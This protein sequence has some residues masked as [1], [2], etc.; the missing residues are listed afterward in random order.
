MKVPT[1]ILLAG[2]V[3]AAVAVGFGCGDCGAAP[4]S[5]GE[6]ERADVPE[7]TPDPIGDERWEEQTAS[8]RGFGFELLRRARQNRDDQIVM[9][10]PH[11]A[12][13]MAAR[14]T[15]GVDGD[16]KEDVAGQ[17]GWPGDGERVHGLLHELNDEFARQGGGDTSYEHLNVLW[18]DDTADV[19]ADVLEGLAAYYDDGIHRIGFAEDVEETTRRIDAWLAALSN[20][21]FDR[22]LAGQTLPERPGLVATGIAQFDG[23]WQYGF[24][25]KEQPVDF[26]NADGSVDQVE[27]MRGD[28]M[29]RFARHR[30]T[31][32]AAVA[33]QGANAA[34][35]AMMPTDED[36]DFSD[37]I[38]DFDARDFDRVVDALGGVGGGEVVLPRFEAASTIALDEHLESTADAAGADAV[39]QG[40]YLRVDEFGGRDATDEERQRHDD[41]TGP[42]KVRFDRPFLFAVYD[43]A[44]ETLLLL[45]TYGG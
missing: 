42:D 4:E 41:S 29:Y 26:R 12:A 13:E 15:V 7:A 36:A 37:W 34:F 6:L 23:R 3:A 28:Q 39:V 2:T 21:R 25:R 18:A 5:P 35:V 22:L 10:A 43:Q 44:T 40:A 16:S 30:S 8:M 9:V 11:A 33:Y 31:L 32:A 45:G 17:L 27:M 24:D 38:A 19:D 1:H 14:L 20:N